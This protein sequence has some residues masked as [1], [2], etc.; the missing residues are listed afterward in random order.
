MMPGVHGD[1][2]LSLQTPSPLLLPSSSGIFKC[3]YLELEN[4]NGCLRC[5]R[6]C[7][8]HSCKW[9]GFLLSFPSLLFTL[10]SF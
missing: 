5:V 6:C 7:A 4:V 3:P 2:N 9:T 10:Q 8:K 1:S